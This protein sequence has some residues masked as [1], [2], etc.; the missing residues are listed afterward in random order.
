MDELSEDLA[1]L[2]VKALLR[3]VISYYVYLRRHFVARLNFFRSNSSPYLGQLRI[4]NVHQNNC[5]LL[6]IM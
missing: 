5:T 4:L 1:H 2:D 6:K 3:H